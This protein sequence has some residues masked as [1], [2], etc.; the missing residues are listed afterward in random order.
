[1]ELNNFPPWQYAIVIAGFLT[2]FFGLIHYEFYNKVRIAIILVV[3][4]SLLL[5]IFAVVVEP[6]INLW[7]E[8]YHALVAKNMIDHPFK[9][10]LYS[11]PWLS[12]DISDWGAN[13]I[14]LHKQPL[15]LWQMAL[16]MKMFGTNEIALRLT[17]VLMLT[18]A[19]FFTFRIGKLLIDNKV[20]LYAAALFSTNYFVFRLMNGKEA[21]DHNDIAFLFYVTSSIWAWVEYQYC[22][23]PKKS[24][25]WV[26]L[27]GLFAGMAVLN[28]WITGLI[29]FSA[30][31]F[32]ILAEKESRSDLNKYFHLL[33]AFL[34]SVA[35][36]LPWQ[37]YISIAFPVESAQENAL[38]TQ[39]FSQIVEGHGGGNWYHLEMLSLIYGNI[40]PYIFIP[41]LTSFF[42]RSNNK[43]IASAL[44]IIILI[45]YLFFT[46]AATKMRAFTLPVVALISIGFA[47]LAYELFDFISANVKSIAAARTII[48]AFLLLTCYLNMNMPEVETSYGN[49]VDFPFRNGKF[50][51]AKSKFFLCLPSSAIA[52]KRICHF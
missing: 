48:I 8:Q 25:K 32:N 9:P 31:F 21:T 33:T 39:N 47:A 41:S 44:L 16:S 35:I 45:I 52:W 17:S 46:I 22:S 19:T 27:I 36:F 14:W 3:I 7:D 34:V 40:A 12:Y 29:I 2:I 26:I 38:N 11:K 15:F 28:K 5:R 23:D 13:H 30:W 24:R 6:F 18:I 10:M 20:G 43:I 49:R 50:D 37:I 42:K 51:R 1:M 4:G